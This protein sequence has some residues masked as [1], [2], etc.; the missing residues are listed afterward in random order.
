MSFG[1]VS[2]FN[3]ILTFMGY[4]KPNPFIEKNSSDTIY[5]IACGYKEV[6]SFSKYGI[7]FGFFI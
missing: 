1:L 5:P 3:G 6:N 4:S 7:W 2:L